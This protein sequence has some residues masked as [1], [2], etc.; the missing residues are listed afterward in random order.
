MFGCVKF[1]LSCNV[2]SYRDYYFA[3]ANTVK[4]HL[5]SRWIKTQQYYYETDPK[6][7][8][9]CSPFLY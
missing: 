6:V 4:D 7:T 1:F 2:L 3:L 9:I 8:S 5:V